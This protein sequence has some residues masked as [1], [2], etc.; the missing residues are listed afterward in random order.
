[1]RIFPKADLTGRNT[2]ALPAR[3]ARLIELENRTDFKQLKELLEEDSHV[4]VLGEGSNTVFVDTDL[5]HTVIHLKP[6]ATMTQGIARE[7]DLFVVDAGL[8]WRELVQWSVNQGLGGIENLAA[9]PGACG[10]APVQN[11]GAYGVELKDVLEWVEV[12]DWQQG[13]FQRL[14]NAECQFDYR[15]SLFKR[16]PHRPWLI[17][18]LALRLR[19]DAP[20]RLEYAGV[21]EALQAQGI[22]PQQASY[23]QVAQAIT[24][25]RA[26]KLPDPRTLPNAGSFFKNPVISAQKLQ[27]LLARW[28]G[29]PHWQQTD[30][31]H[32]V[33]AAW[34]IEKTG[35]KNQRVGEAG[36]YNK[37]A[38]ILVNHGQ[39]TGA[40]VA[41]L[42]KKVIESVK[43][44][45]G[46]VLEPE[47]VTVRAT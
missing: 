1:M 34:L 6:P 35:L 11:I 36:F 22:S 40:D 24:A 21:R 2:L 16:E 14:S 47:P 15:N 5:P 28:P 32:K 44:A 23:A 9:I 20:L 29:L 45:C 42:A 38:L 37:H 26:S 18:R 25:L 41:G 10:A 19:P 3:C 46:I 17:T 30:G 33:S 8:S 43:Q 4:C 13:L 12:L 7:N 39:A 27:A 31:Q